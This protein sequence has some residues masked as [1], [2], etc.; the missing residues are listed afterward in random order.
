LTATAAKAIEYSVDFRQICFKDG[1]R[2]LPDGH[3]QCNQRGRAI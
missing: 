2:R 3:T 1:K